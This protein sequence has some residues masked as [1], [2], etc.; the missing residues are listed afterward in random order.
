MVHP[1]HVCGVSGHPWGQMLRRDQSVGQEEEQKLVNRDVIKG[2][3]RK[4]QP[5]LAGWGMRMVRV[6]CEQQQ[7][8]G[9]Q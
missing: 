5:A 8:A 3:A 4:A 7:A 9:V 2:V 1:V 6:G